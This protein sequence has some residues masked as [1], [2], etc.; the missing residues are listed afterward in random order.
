VQLSG[1]TIY[2]PDPQA[3][4]PRRNLRVLQPAYRFPEIVDA[5]AL[6]GA[7]AECMAIHEAAPLAEDFVLAFHWQ[8]A[9]RYERIAAFAR[10]LVLG[11]PEAMQSDRAVYVV[12]DGDIAR[13]LGRILHDELL[14]R[15][16]LLIV[17]GV[18]LTDFDYIDF[19]AVRRPSNTVPITIKSLLFSQDPRKG[20]P[21]RH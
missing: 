4:L 12:M 13:T 3:V 6:S 21:H 9:P 14:V 5:A 10:G 18:H 20:M 8:G 7:I 17:D 15:A 1:N 16:P 11:L 2:V 19:G